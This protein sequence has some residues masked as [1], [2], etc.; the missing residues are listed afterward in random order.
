MSESTLVDPRPEPAPPE[1]APPSPDDPPVA[2]DRPG[3]F[4][5]PSLDGIRAAAIAVVFL[6]HV[7]LGTVVPGIFGV[8]VFFFLSGYLITTLLRMEVEQTGRVLF[9]QFYLRRTLRIFPPLYAVLAIVAVLTAAGLLGPPRWAGL[10]ASA[11][12]LSNYYLIGHG[13][14]AMPPGTDVL[15]SLAIEEHFYLVFPLV[16]VGLRRAV[17]EP[18]RQ[19]AWLL[20]GCAA[21]MAWRCWLTY[22]DPAGHHRALRVDHATDTRLDSMLFGCAMAIWGNPARDRPVW[23][24]RVLKLGLF[25]LGMA[26]LLVTLLVRSDGFR[27]SIRFTLQGLALWPIFTAAILYPQWL[28]FAPLNWRPVR[29]VG[30]ISYTL[31]LVHHVI[32]ELFTRHLAAPMPVRAGLTAVASVLVATASY[33]GLERPCA[34]LRKRFSRVGA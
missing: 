26:V 28:P 27:E 29:F 8:T 15:W 16:Y 13:V 11:V 3:R 33:Y 21:V 18:R 7:G 12:Y 5:I 25:P 10:G 9:G 2:V 23:S 4:F 24:E 17:P 30:A 20:A 32:L 19:A 6:S 14:A 31:Y 1:P 22:H 34:R